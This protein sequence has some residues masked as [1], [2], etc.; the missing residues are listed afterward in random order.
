MGCSTRQP[1]RGEFS[2]LFL[3]RPGGEGPP[4]YLAGRHVVVRELNESNL[5]QCG[6]FAD[7][8]NRLRRTSLEVEAA[9]KNVRCV[10]FCIVRLFLCVQGTIRTIEETFLERSVEETKTS[11]MQL[12][13]GQF[14]RIVGLRDTM[15][16]FC[17]TGLLPSEQT[18]VGWGQ[19]GASAVGLQKI[20]ELEDTVSAMVTAWD[21][22]S[23]SSSS[24]SSS[25]A[26]L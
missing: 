18:D 4:T 13:T 8:S 23:H 14:V 17:A 5:R 6:A 9:F 12:T 25:T 10:C 22:E 21:R 26:R 24:S 2:R 20:S 3:L 11:P 16:T 15:E 1:V 19:G 7:Y